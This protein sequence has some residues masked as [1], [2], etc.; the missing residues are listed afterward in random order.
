MTDTEGLVSKTWSV[1]IDLGEHDGMTRAVARLHTGDR[2]S[3][4]GT[5]A[6]RLNPGDPNVPE[7]GDELAAARALSQLAHTLLEAAADDIAGVLHEQV[8]LTGR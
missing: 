7:I 6:A 3:L 8:D 2:T 1:Q 5:G 4:T